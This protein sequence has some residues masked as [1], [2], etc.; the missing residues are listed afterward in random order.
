MLVQLFWYPLGFLIHMIEGGW[1]YRKD[2]T[3][4]SIWAA[5]LVP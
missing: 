2:M 5:Y 3:N 1:N 4:L